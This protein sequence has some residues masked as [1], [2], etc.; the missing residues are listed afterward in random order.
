MGNLQG[1][2]K[3]KIEEANQILNSASSKVQQIGH[4]NNLGQDGKL[5]S[6]DEDEDMDEG[7]DGG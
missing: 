4:L 6:N 2:V 3:G 5:R 1:M 7:I